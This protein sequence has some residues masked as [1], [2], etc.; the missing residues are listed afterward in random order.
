MLKLIIFLSNLYSLGVTYIYLLTQVSPFELFS[1]SSDRWVW[2]DYL[3]ENYLSYSF[4]RIID[5]MIAKAID[6][7]YQAIQ[8]I[9]QV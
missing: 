7:R 4:G 8:Q 2:R 5:K 9:L 3:I 6:R 1:D